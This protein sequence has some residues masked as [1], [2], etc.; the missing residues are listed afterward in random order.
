MRDFVLRKQHERFIAN[1]QKKVFRHPPNS[2]VV[3]FKREKV[4]FFK[5]EAP[6]QTFMQ[7]RLSR[8]HQTL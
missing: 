6:Q 8:S 5:K 4:D 7:A 1:P 3:F 2:S